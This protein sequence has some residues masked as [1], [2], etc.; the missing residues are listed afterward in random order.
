MLFLRSARLDS[1]VFRS[2]SQSSWLF[3][4]TGTRSPRTEQH[5]A[6]PLATG[7]FRLWEYEKTRP[8]R[9]REPRHGCPS[10]CVCLS[11]WLD[12]DRCERRICILCQRARTRGDTYRSRHT[13]DRLESGRIDLALPPILFFVLFCQETLIVAQYLPCWRPDVDDDRIFGRR[14][15]GTVVQ[16]YMSVQSRGRQYGRT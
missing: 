5:G 6:L 16:M 15:R 10:W 13:R 1:R 8:E 14:Q 9:R 7:F 3:T 11:V 4:R 12:R 2:F